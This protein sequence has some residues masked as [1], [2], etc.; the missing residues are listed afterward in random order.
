MS[1]LQAV[2]LLLAFSL[3]SCYVRISDISKLQAFYNDNFHYPIVQIFHNDFFLRSAPF[4]DIESVF[5]EAEYKFQD[6]SRYVMFNCEKVKR[7]PCH[8][9]RAT[10]MSAMN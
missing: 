10:A 2:M 7:K 3:A 8:I 5:Q 1:S 6:F 9:Q 4:E